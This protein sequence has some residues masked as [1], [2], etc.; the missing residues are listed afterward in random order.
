MLTTFSTHH[1]PG[2]APIEVAHEAAL[3]VSSP[4]HRASVYRL[5]EGASTKGPRETDSE[6]LAGHRACR[7]R[8]GGRRH[9]TLPQT[10]DGREML[11]AA[12][13]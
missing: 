11:R 13:G 4:F 10:E 8:E 6:M 1:L 9:K 3:P 2:N 7:A 5:L 12:G